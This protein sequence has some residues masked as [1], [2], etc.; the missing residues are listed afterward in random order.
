LGSG[1][2]AAGGPS[3]HSVPRLGID[4]FVIDGLSIGGTLIFLTQSTEGEFEPA[5]GPT[6]T[7]DGPSTTAFLFAPRVG[8]GVMFN[9]VVGLWPRGGITY[10]NVNIDDNDPPPGDTETSDSG[11]AFTIEVPLVLSPAEHVALTVGPTIDIPLSGTRE[12]TT[13]GVSSEVDHTL[14]EFGIRAGLLAWF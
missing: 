7:V 4:Y 14:F 1:A 13:A 8:Y 11:F 9:D 12:T 10:Y 5:G 2:V 3:Y 6:V